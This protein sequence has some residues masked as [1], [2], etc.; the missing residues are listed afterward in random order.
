MPTFGL[1]DGGGVVGSAPALGLAPC[2]V[3]PYLRPSPAEVI[4]RPLTRAGRRRC[5]SSDLARSTPHQSQQNAIWLSRC[6]KPT[7]PA[8][9]RLHVR[10]RR[11]GRALRRC[12]VV[13]QI[14]HHYNCQQS[15]P[16]SPQLARGRLRLGSRLR[17][18][19]LAVCPC[20]RLCPFRVSW[21]R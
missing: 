3:C 15:A 20:L 7:R 5:A 21:L 1:F 9:G 19:A 10:A 18:D 17:A 4:P 2:T 14:E 16:P 13:S 8:T 11:H 12:L 6:G